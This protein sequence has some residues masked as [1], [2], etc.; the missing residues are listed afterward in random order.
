MCRA[1]PL[2]TVSRLAALREANSLRIP[3]A[4]S[5]LPSKNRARNSAWRRKG[6]VD[7]LW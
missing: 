3:F 2:E 6:S 5:L 4:E 7:G 1:G